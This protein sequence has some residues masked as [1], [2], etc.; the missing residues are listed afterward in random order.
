M[1]SEVEQFNLFNRFTS[2]VLIN[3]SHPGNIGASARAIKNMG[4]NNL[5]LLNPKDFPNDIATYRAKAAIDVVNSARVAQSL[6]EVIQDCNFIVGTSARNRKIPWPLKEPK[7]ATKE[8]IDRVIN[9]KQK[10]AILFGREDRGL[11]NEELGRCNLH[12]H[13]PT[14]EEYSSLNLSQAVQ[15]IS[16]ELRLAIKEV[17]SKDPKQEWDVPIATDQEIELLLNHIDDLMLEL[18]FYDPKNPRKLLERV[19]RL[20]KRTDLDTMES[21]ILRGVIASIQEKLK[22]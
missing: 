6:D 11:T 22:N 2:F 19:R 21:S 5:T 12:I 15:I 14:S 10:V 4:F 17:I 3:T 1:L 13:I 9:K 8:I 20:F 7:E 16:Y 18:D